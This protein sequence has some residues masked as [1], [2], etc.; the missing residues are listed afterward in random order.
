M[1]FFS[2]L[3]RVRCVFC[4][5]W[6]TPERM[7][8]AQPKIFF[9]SFQTR[10]QLER[11]LVLPSPLD[12]YCFEHD[13]LT[14]SIQTALSADHDVDFSGT[15]KFLLAPE[16]GSE[17]KDNRQSKKLAFTLC[18]VRV[19]T[20]GRTARR[21]RMSTSTSTSMSMIATMMTMV[22]FWATKTTHC[23]VSFR[24]NNT[25]CFVFNI[26]TN[27]SSIVDEMLVWY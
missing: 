11:E 21:P 25:Y 14:H 9:F 16:F 19:E 23:D 20:K 26:S 13:N 1:F 24:F 17:N 27:E 10:T 4:F 12:R 2:S 5:V 3:G 15:P 7:N 18:V 6:E 22:S 8:P